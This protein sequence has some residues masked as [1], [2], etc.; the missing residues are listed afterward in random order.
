VHHF[1]LV[2]FY[3]CHDKAQQLGNNPKGGKFMFVPEQLG[4]IAGGAKEVAA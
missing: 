4:K 3:S 2:S 1:L